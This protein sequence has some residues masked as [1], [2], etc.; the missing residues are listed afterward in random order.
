LTAPDTAQPAASPPHIWSAIRA[1]MRDVRGVPKAGEFKSGL[2][3]GGI[4]YR[5]QRYDDLADKLGAAFRDHGIM[6]QAKT[7]DVKQESWDKETSNGHQRWCRVIVTKAFFF[8]SLQ[9]GSRVEIEASGE[10]VDNSDKATNKAETGALKRALLQAFLLA[11]GEED[12]DDTRPDDTGRP[13]EV[14]VNDPWF[15]VDQALMAPSTP[16]T[17][18][19]AGKVAEALDYIKQV[20]SRDHLVKLATWC[21]R[22]RILT[23]APDNT[24]IAARLHALREQFEQKTTAQATFPS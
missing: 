1:V 21:A 20:E 5:F 14:A 12:P 2:G 19:Q 11:S 9:D 7:S 8:T 16:P 23:V 18:A 3:R 15:A 4:Q 13:M 17:D 22:L 6:I 10:G 24:S